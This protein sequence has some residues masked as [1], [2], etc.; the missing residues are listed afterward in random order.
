MTIKVPFDPVKRRQ[1][2]AYPPAIP[3]Q[4]P[5]PVEP[6]QVTC[7]T[8]RFRCEKLH[9]VLSAADCQRRYKAAHTDVSG[10]PNADR[11]QARVAANSTGA[12]RGCDVGPKLIHPKLVVRKRRGA[13]A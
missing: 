13:G 7:G 3:V 12:C 8:D 4:L 2:L 5:S 9:A 6:S 11:M 10:K 1:L